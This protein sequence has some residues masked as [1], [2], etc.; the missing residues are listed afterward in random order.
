[1]HLFHMRETKRTK[2]NSI[3][4]ISNIFFLKK[5]VSYRYQ[6]LNNSKNIV[7]INIDVVDLK[8]TINIFSFKGIN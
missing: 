3:I 8:L 2:Q 7:Q 5:H 4:K 1:M 6:T